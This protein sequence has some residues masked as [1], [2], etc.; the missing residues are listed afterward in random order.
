[1][2]QF[3]RN[4]FLLATAM[5]SIVSTPGIVSDELMNKSVST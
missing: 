5:W 1:M 4:V 2:T 3:S